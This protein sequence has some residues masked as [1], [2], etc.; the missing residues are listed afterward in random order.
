MVIRARNDVV[1]VTEQVDLTIQFKDIYG[2]PIDTDSFPTISL[3]QPSG[4]MALAPTSTGVAHTGTGHYSYIFTIR[5][6]HH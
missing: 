1:D 6:A 2:N 3:I 5:F 4:L